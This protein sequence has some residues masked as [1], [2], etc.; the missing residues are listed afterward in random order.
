M[1]KPERGELFA[2]DAAAGLFAFFCSL[3]RED[4]WRFFGLLQRELVVARGRSAPSSAGMREHEA[5]RALHEAAVRLGH[6]PSVREFD[7][8][9][10]NHP[11][12]DLPPV[13]S[14]KRWLG[15]SSWN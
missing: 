12:L 6:P 2:S 11:E 10:D 4:Q 14:I 1:S 7:W 15:V 3:K 8:L 13:R 5:L 9:R